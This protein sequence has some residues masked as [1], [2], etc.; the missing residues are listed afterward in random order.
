M[1][2]LLVSPTRPEGASGAAPSRQVATLPAFTAE[3]QS[4]LALPEAMH[5]VLRDLQVTLRDNGIEAA[6]AEIAYALME[7]LA[8]RPS[9]CRGL[10]AAY[11][12]EE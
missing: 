4:A 1:Q 11:L 7:A 2:R 5:W 6:P 10:L 12:L 3:D 8:Y 9:L